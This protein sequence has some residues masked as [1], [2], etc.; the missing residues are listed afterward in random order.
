[1]DLLVIRHGQSEADILNVNSCVN[2]GA[3]LLR[4]QRM[5]TLNS[6]LRENQ[7]AMLWVTMLL[8]LDFTAVDIDYI[9]Q[10]LRAAGEN[11]FVVCLEPFI[12]NIHFTKPHVVFLAVVGIEYAE[13]LPVQVA[14][15]MCLPF[16]P[17]LVAVALPFLVM[18]HGR[19]GHCRERPLRIREVGVEA[20]E[21]CG[22]VFGL[23]PPAKHAV[24]DG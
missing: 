24:H 18:R 19:F 20:V 16:R 3:H 2:K 6:F 22:Y 17:K 23:H 9:P 11:L 7:V 14:S 10:K 15:R 12:G 8:S 5:C 21:V 1:M 4:L 13:P